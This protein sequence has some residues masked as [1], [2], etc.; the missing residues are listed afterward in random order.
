MRGNGILCRD[1][2][3]LIRIRMNS[4]CYIFLFFS[5]YSQFKALTLE[6]IFYWELSI[7]VVWERI[8]G[9]F[10]KMVFHMIYKGIQNLLC[11]NFLWYFHFA[12]MLI[13]LFHSLIKNDTIYSIVFQWNLSKRF[14]RYEDTFFS[15]FISI[16]IHA[17]TYTPGTAS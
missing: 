8:Q 1:E 4:S 13:S 9:N 7:A 14:K 15:V 5:L 11:S 16:V 12:Y 2:K 17:A 10:N 3:Q 6:K